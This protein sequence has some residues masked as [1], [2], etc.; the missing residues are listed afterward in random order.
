MTTPDGGDRRPDGSGRGGDVY[1]TAVGAEHWESMLDTLDIAPGRW[2]D[3]PVLSGTHIRQYPDG[4]GSADVRLQ[5]AR[6]PQVVEILRHHFP[7]GHID[8]IDLD[9]PPD[10]PDPC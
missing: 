7:P 1:L 2:M 4:S 10:Q 5:L 9:D 3:R 8:H 6:P